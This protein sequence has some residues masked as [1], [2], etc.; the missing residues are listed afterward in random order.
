MTCGVE[1]LFFNLQPISDD[2]L[3]NTIKNFQQYQI[4]AN[5]LSTSPDSLYLSVYG[6]IK[7]CSET[8]IS[9]WTILCVAEFYTTLVNM[10]INSKLKFF[11]KFE[12]QICQIYK[13]AYL[14]C[15]PFWYYSSQSK[16]SLCNT[17]YTFRIW[18]LFVTNW[19][20]ATNI[21]SGDSCYSSFCT[22][23]TKLIFRLWIFYNILTPLL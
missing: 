1:I 4:A 20:R 2:V 12:F 13:W 19:F 7:N 11:L 9:P 22:E 3:Q 6:P 15:F 5:F 17:D 14:E 23:N 18:E 16:T 8:G 21:K 10:L